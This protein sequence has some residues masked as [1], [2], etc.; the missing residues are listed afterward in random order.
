[1]STQTRTAV[2]T[3]VAAAPAPYVGMPCTDMGKI[4]P[5]E[6]GEIMCTLLATSG[7]DAGTSEW[8]PFSRE[9]LQL[10]E[11]GARCT[12]PVGDTAFAR[13][14]DNYWVWCVGTQY[15]P[16]TVWTIVQP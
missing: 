9:G 10:V 4:A 1:V 12:S 2:P 11:R 5:G 7:P 8:R 13:S 16:N 3:T 14:T 6:Q 15:N